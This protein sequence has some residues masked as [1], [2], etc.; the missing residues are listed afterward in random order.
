MGYAAMREAH[1]RAERAVEI[2]DA[3]I[4]GMAFAYGATLATGHVRDFEGCDL[5]IV[6]PWRD[7]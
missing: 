3:L 7:A 1:E 2:Q 4:G 5:S 6:D